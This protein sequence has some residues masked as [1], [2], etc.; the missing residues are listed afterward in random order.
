MASLRKIKIQ[1]EP[2]KRPQCHDA[3]QDHEAF[4]NQNDDSHQGYEIFK[5]KN[6]LMSLIHFE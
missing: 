6:H 3:L 5:T 4:P 2:S 1:V